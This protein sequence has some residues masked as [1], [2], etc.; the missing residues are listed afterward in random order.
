MV[1]KEDAILSE[2]FMWQELEL[3]DTDISARHGH[4]MLL[5]NGQFVVLFGSLED[6]ILNDVLVFNPSEIFSSNFF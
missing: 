5:V 1:Q 6:K 4:R 3:P 2:I